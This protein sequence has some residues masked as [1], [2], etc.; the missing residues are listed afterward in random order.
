MTIVVKLDLS[1]QEY[2]RGSPMNKHL[3][4]RDMGYHVLFVDICE[5]RSGEQAQA[6]KSETAK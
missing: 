2:Q 1:H 5:N 6:R 3:D 4:F